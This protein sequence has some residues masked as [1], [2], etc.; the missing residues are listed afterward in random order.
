M[1]PSST[2]GTGSGTSSEAD[3]PDATGAVSPGDGGGPT[4]AS[5][6]PTRPRPVGGAAAWRR[7]PLASPARPADER[8]A[9]ERTRYGRRGA[10]EAVSDW[11]A[12]GRAHPIALLIAGLLLGGWLVLRL[13]TPGSVRF[14]AIEVGQCL[15]V[16][17]G[18]ATSLEGPA[19]PI[20]S[21]ELVRATV[22]LGGAEP[23]PCDGSHGHEVASR[24]GYDRSFGDQYP[25]EPALLAAAQAPCEAAFLTHVGRPL[26]GSSLALTVVP[27]DERRWAEGVRD[28]LCLVHRADGQFLQ[29]PALDSGA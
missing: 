13:I 22:L 3:R 23:A 19:R 16:R 1:T 21:P 14:E 7:N 26:E 12:E 4:T 29:Q 15:Y 20:G 10:T 11:I 17:T 2:P 8:V 25:G 28:A 27:P 18:S 24:T 6:A 5:E 9:P